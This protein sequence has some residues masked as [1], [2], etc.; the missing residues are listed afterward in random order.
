MG[1]RYFFAEAFTAGICTGSPT[2]VCL[3]D[4]LPSRDEMQLLAYTFNHPVTAFVNENVSSP[5]IRY[6]TPQTEIEAC[7]HATLAAAA[8]L[9]GEKN[10]QLNFLTGSG[11]SIPVSSRD[12]LISMC[13]PR[14]EMQEKIPSEALLR[15]MQVRD[16][17]HSGI[18]PE[19][20]TLFI[21]LEDTCM[22]NSIEPD[23]EAMMQAAPLLKEV[24]IHSRG[25][26][27]VD[28]TL[29]SFC[30]WI[31]INEDPVTGSVH[32]VLAPYWSARLLKKQ[33]KAYQAS[34]RGGHVYLESLNDGVVISGYCSCSPFPLFR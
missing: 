33:L 13:Y 8:V 23:F 24:V 14:F 18:C 26:S 27:E 4:T 16:F 5:F 19:L 17:I 2:A 20:D 34:P 7:G 22:L 21:E 11:K 6:F 12:G 1:G 30:P 3:Y 9:L 25:T 10:S 29:R 28:F 31:G 15:S 32:S